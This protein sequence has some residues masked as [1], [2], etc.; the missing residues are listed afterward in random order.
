MSY[1]ITTEQKKIVD[2]A[3]AA[4][5]ANYDVFVEVLE[6]NCVIDTN[7]LDCAVIS[8]VIDEQRH[9]N[10][11]PCDN[12]EIHKKASFFLY[13]F[14][15]FKPIRAKIHYTNDLRYVAVNELFVFYYIL[16]MLQ[17]KDEKISTPFF[18]RFIYMLLY[19]DIH[20]EPMFMTISLIDSL[21]KTA[22]IL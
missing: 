14:I 20:P 22:K 19:R 13:W 21:A 8:W 1:T 4:I 16:K 15:K 12:I 6:L 2:E 18:N 11:H 10:F 7:L 9:T 5:R 17:I 3:C